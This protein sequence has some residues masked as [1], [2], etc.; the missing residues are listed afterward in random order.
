MSTLI[1]KSPIRT[2][3][4]EAE[5]RITDTAPTVDTPSLSTR[6]AEVGITLKMG[7]SGSSGSGFPTT[8]GSSFELQI[9]DP[10]YKFQDLFLSV[11]DD[12]RFQV[13][14]EIPQLGTWHG[15]VKS[16][17]QTR[18][19]S[20]KTSAGTT[21][22]RCFDGLALLGEEDTAINARALDVRS[23]LVEAFAVANPDLPIVFYSDLSAETIE[24]DTVGFDKLRPIADNAR[25]Y[26]PPQP[27]GPSEE[28][29]EEGLEGETLREQLDDLCTR[30]TAAAYQDIRQETWAVVDVAAIGAPVTGERYDGSRWESYVFPEQSVQQSSGE[31]SIKDEADALK[32]K[33]SL[34]AVCTEIKN[35]VTDPGFEATTNGS[36][37]VYWVLTDAE[38]NS[39]GYL[40]ETASG[41]N[42]VQVI[43]VS[44]IPIL[45]E[46]DAIRHQ[47][48]TLNDNINATVTARP[49]YGNGDDSNLY[50]QVSTSSR[51]FTYSPVDQGGP[52]D[53]LD[54]VKVTITPDGAKVERYI[55]QFLKKLTDNPID[56][57]GR[58]NKYKVVDTW[59]YEADGEGRTTVESDAGGFLTILS[60]GDVT[61]AKEW[62][63]ERYDSDPYERFSKWRATNLLALRPPPYERLSTQ[64]IGDWA[65]LGTRLRVQKPGEKR[66]TFFI[67]LKGR[68][69]DLSPS[70]PATDLEDVELPRAVTDALPT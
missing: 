67:P 24:G 14:L 29:E 32:T 66:D 55:F 39:D 21:T 48:A 17:L 56:N 46:V 23:F 16:T 38:R 6:P 59:C 13:E 3:A 37:L 34:R 64:L 10:Q 1:Y 44:E 69:L 43:D 18:R 41:G 5:V 57:L 28:Q 40:V 20:R 54:Q 51:I 25:A 49:K 27:N 50:T 2:G 52:H 26:E 19:L 70:K 35:W 22:V 30:L 53:S 36:D 12:R 4:G 60:S 68:D 61:P 11:F 7:D 45:E 8:L 58:D 31:A 9:P 42:A 65:P 47:V 62:D 33:K 15:Y 63:S